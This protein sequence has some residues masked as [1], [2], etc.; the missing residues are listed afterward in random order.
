MSQDTRPFANGTD[1]EARWQAQLTAIARA[2][3]Y[4]PTPNLAAGRARQPGP[5][6]MISPRVA[7]GL[8]WAVAAIVLA[9]AILFAIP[10]TRAGL[11]QFLQ[12]GSVRI[13]LA[14]TAT[15]SPA[16]TATA[17]A[18]SP[19][20]GTAS[21]RPTP[22]PAPTPLL[23]VLNLAGQTTFEQAKVRVPFEL[24]LPAYPAGLG[25][26]DLAYVQDL[27]GPAAILVWLEPGDPD[28]VRLTLH[29]LTSTTI[30]NK[31]LEPSGP[32]TAPSVEATRVNGRPAVW[33]TGPYVLFTLSGTFKEY[34]LIEGHVLIWTDGVL[35]YRLETRQSRDEAVRTAE[36]LG[37]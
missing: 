13:F 33:T 15:P 31:L 7:R 21:P 17:P 8:A 19:P 22:T 30:A 23:S 2:L 3:P 6:P 5:R 1:P 36:S 35:T 32:S 34:R 11:L 10:A 24:L 9:L 28:R 16:P 29:F 20:A 26:P 25:E 12:I 37:Q 18:G 27:G 4:P 14:P